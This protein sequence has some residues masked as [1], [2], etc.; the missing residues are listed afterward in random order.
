MTNYK[1][2]V[3]E[4]QKLG[5]VISYLP[6]ERDLSGQHKQAKDSFEQLKAKMADLESKNAEEENEELKDQ[7][8]VISS[9]MAEQV[10]IIKQLEDRSS[11]AIITITLF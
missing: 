6:S 7:I 8:S 5:E 4:L 1:S 11:Y 3:N 10:N 2:T 9:S